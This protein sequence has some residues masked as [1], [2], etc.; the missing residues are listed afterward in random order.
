MSVPE[1][2]NVVTLWSR[3]LRMKVD[4]TVDRDTGGALEIL[5][6]VD[7]RLIKP[8]ALLTEALRLI[9]HSDMFK[10]RRA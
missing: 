7:S 6:G 10:G 1:N 3:A 9:Q 5:L 8:E 2:C 4:I